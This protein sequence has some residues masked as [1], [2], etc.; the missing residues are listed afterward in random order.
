MS[1][2]VSVWAQNTFP[3]K[4][5]SVQSYQP[6]TK[7]TYKAEDRYGDPFSNPETSSP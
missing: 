3:E 7:P 5:D 1:T 6:E 4:K 2:T